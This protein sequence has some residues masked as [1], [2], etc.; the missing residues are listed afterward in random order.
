MRAS[1]EQVRYGV[2]SVWL[3][4][5]RKAVGSVGKRVSEFNLQWDVR[6]RFPF[7]GQLEAPKGAVR[8]FEN[9]EIG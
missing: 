6:V 5:H 2:L 4:K 3:Q 7:R 9:Y 1:P 8:S